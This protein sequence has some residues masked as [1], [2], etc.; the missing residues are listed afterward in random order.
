[1]FYSALSYDGL[2]FI[3]NQYEWESNFAF[4]PG[5][6]WV[7]RLVKWIVSMGVAEE[8]L[9]RTLVVLGVILINKLLT[10]YTS[11]V[12]YQ[13]A[14]NYGGKGLSLSAGVLFLFNPSS[15]FYHSVYSEPIFACLTMQAI[16]FALDNQIKSSKLID[17]PLEYLRVNAKSLVLFS[18]SMTV[19]STGL[20]LSLIFG[21]PILCQLWQNISKFD[22]G[23]CIRTGVTGFLTLSMFLL[24]FLL[25]LSFGYLQFC[26]Q[27][28]PSP[29]CL[30]SPPNIYSY[31]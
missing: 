23:R 22:I 26:R 16:K 13:I 21:V 6:V 19:R 25:Y 28:T 2:I 24:P 30:N 31:V 27:P 15:V 18:L 8:E 4:L 20:F 9:Q 10:A 1:M 7:V 3:E 17:Q 11:L 12:L 29:F 14:G 5:F